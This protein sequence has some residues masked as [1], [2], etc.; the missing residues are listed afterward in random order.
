[1]N[2]QLLSWVVTLIGL[3]GFWLSGK[4]LWWAWYINIANQLLWVAFA[5]F[6]GY[7]IFLVAAGF[8][9]VVF[10]RNAYLWTKEHFTVEASTSKAARDVDYLHPKSRV[11]VGSRDD[12][13]CHEAPTSGRSDAYRACPTGEHRGGWQHRVPSECELNSEEKR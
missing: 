12:H 10:S 13:V 9:L 4:K 2:D 6:S 8:Y 5:I 7:Y 3:I 1:M 11:M